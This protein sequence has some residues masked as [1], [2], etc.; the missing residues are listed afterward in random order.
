MSGFGSQPAG[1]SPYG[2]G[3]PTTAPEDG[4]AIFRDPAT[5]LSTGSRLIDSVTKDYVYD[6]YG[7]AVGMPDVQQLVLL[8]TSTRKG[9]A[10]M[11]EL[12][13]E[14]AKIDRITVNTARRVDV[15]MREAVQHLVARGLIEIQGTTVEVVQQGR[16]QMSLLWRDLTGQLD[17]D[18]RTDV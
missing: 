8:A 10:S 17:A 9:S 11:R 7:R 3:T 5:G 6:E 1:S 13:Q 16:I 18:Q 2:L 4:G 14:L 15:T 12:G